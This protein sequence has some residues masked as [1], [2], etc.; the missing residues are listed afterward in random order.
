MLS[1]PFLLHL[2]PLPGTSMPLQ[3]LTW[4]A[5]RFMSCNVG[6]IGQKILKQTN[7]DVQT[8]AKKL[9]LEHQLDKFHQRYSW[10]GLIPDLLKAEASKHAKN[11]YSVVMRARSNLIIIY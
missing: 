4:L 3:T 5:F 1:N 9:T 10:H 2:M 7:S 8:N 11:I 6:T